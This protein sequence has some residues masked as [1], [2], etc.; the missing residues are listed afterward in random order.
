MD[1]TLKDE[2]ETFETHRSDLVARA[3]G[4]FVLIHGREIVGTYETE[5]DAINEGYRR[6]G[7]VAFLVKRIAQ[8]DEPVNF[9]S[10]FVAL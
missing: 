4:K 1:T 8:T 6:F 3:S 10:G 2:L 9:V 5:N 7:N